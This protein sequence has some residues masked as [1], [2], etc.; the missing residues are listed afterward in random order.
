VSAPNAELQAGMMRVKLKTTVETLSSL[1][2]S[3]A[4]GSD[5][6]IVG[7]NRP[8]MKALPTAFVGFCFCKKVFY[9]AMNKG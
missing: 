6:G 8:Q 4:L 5:V 2:A 7:F 9:R 3:F 1:S